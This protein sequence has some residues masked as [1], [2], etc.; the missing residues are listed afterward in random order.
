VVI[1]P[2]Q[3]VVGDLLRGQSEK[4]RRADAGDGPADPA[5]EKP[6]CGDP[7]QGQERDRDGAGAQGRFGIGE[8]RGR[9]SQPTG[10]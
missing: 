9:R 10:Q 8:P 5:G 2:A 6:R 1:D 3:D 4:G 7:E